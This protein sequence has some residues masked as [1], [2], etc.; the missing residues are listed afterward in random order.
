VSNP[1]FNASPEFSKRGPVVVQQAPTAQGRFGSYGRPG[2]ATA[3]QYGATAPGQYAPYAQYGAAGAA[4]ADAAALEQMYSGPTA[5]TRDTA[6]MTYDDVIIKT[7]G[8][9][10][11]VVA[12]ASVTWY[13]AP[14]LFWIGMIVGLVLG[15]VNS[16]KKNPSPFL[17]SAYAIAEGVFLGGLSYLV[18]YSVGSRPGEDLVLEPIVLQA[19]LATGATFVAA[20]L[21]FRSGKVRVTAKSIRWLLVAMAGYGMFCLVNFALVVFGGMDGWGL[22]SEVTVLGIPLGVIVGVFA[23]AMAAY[24]LIVDFDAIKR[25]VERGVPA[26]LAWTAAF[27][28][29]VTLV[30][31]YLEFLRI[32]AILGGR[33]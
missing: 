14:G 7:A 13:V 19:L 24:S 28:L 33:R 26:K 29:V 23:V 22:R 10:V 11:L 6:R 30:W 21:L 17:I 1:V 20:L 12:S 4:G 18:Q 15:L 3:D 9:L 8:L 27:G 2:A 31:L 16:F 5:T 32:L 25:G